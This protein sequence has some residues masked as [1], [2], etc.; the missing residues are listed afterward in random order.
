VHTVAE[1]EMSASV[2]VDVTAAT[3]GHSDDCS[4]DADLRVVYLATAADTS[5]VNRDEHTL[6]GAVSIGEVSPPHL[7][8]DIDGSDS[9]NDDDDTS[10][11]LQRN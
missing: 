10:Q 2:G 5:C 1:H 11:H 7:I 6:T 9:D 4:T 8:M 3:P